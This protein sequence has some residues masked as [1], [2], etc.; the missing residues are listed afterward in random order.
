MRCS[1]SAGSAQP[2]AQLRGSGK[3]VRRCCVLPCIQCAQLVFG[4]C[5]LLAAVMC[6]L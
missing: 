1:G 6:S 5:P 2:G 4:E 3:S